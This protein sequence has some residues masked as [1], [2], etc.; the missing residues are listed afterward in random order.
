MYSLN[1]FIKTCF[2]R[3][4]GKK[5]LGFFSPKLLDPAGEKNSV[6]LHREGGNK[7]Y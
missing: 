3:P 6:A 2:S 1:V 5:R 7:K 4:L